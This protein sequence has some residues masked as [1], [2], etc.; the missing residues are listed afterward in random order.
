[1]YRLTCLLTIISLLAWNIPI[2]SQT[3]FQNDILISVYEKAGSNAENIKHVME[4]IQENHK[5]ATVFLLEYMPERDLKTLSSDFILDQIRWAYMAKYEFAWCNKLPDSIFFNDVMPYYC[6]D[7]DR[8]N[9]RKEFY[10]YFKPLVKNCNNI[11]EAI[12]SVNL[13]IQKI[14]GVNY[15]VR[16]SKVNISPLQA[17]KEK[18][19]TCT[20]LSILL[21]DAFRSVGIPSRIAGTPMWTNMRGNHSWVEVWIDGKWYFTEYYPDGL[22]KSWFVRDAGKADIQ[23]PEHWIYAVSY[24]PSNTY[25]PLVWDSLSVNIHAE[26]VTER[27]IKLYENKLNSDTLEDDEIWADIVLFKSTVKQNAEDRI[28][29][30]ITVKQ[31]TIEIDFGYSPLPTDDLNRYLKFRLKRNESYKIEFFDDK[32]SVKSLSMLMPDKNEEI[33]RLFENE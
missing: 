5:N 27:Y 23:K 32:G 7:E 28:S 16:R 15:D 20:G 14:L 30:R 3:K 24:K 10:Q 31:D 17:I 6:L 1:M 4:K 25:F 8:D 13:N 29:K 19:A 12:D 22:N 18:M 11:Y 2:I 33:F 9:W 26:N 21:V